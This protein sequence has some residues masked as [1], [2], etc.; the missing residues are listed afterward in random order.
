MGQGRKRLDKRGEMKEM[1]C[2]NCESYVADS[3]QQSIEIERAEYYACY[4][5]GLRFWIDRET[6]PKEK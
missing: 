4:S 5:C 2:P 1:K 6:I 3:H